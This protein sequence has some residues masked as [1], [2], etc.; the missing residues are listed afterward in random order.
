MQIG[1]KK[2]PVC[3]VSLI[4]ME[5]KGLVALGEALTIYPWALQMHVAYPIT[6]RFHLGWVSMKCVCMLCGNRRGV[7][8]GCV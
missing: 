4:A 8:W 5:L 2:T 3:S 6:N 1:A 7:S